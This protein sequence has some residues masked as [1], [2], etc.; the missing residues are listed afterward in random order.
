VDSRPNKVDNGGGTIPGLTAETAGT[1][2]APV[3]GKMEE[4]VL[5]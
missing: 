2:L 4:A 5:N 1:A 3:V